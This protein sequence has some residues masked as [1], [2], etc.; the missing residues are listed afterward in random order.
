VISC[1]AAHGAAV[2]VRQRARAQR[3]RAGI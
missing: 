1:D 3:D 2:G